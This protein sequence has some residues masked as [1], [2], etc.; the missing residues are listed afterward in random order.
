MTIQAYHLTPDDWL[1]AIR[2]RFG[3]RPNV[4]PV[5]QILRR[6]YVRSFK[7]SL[8]MVDAL[9][10]ELELPNRR[11]RAALT[12]LRNEEALFQRRIGHLPVACL[13]LRVADVLG[14]QNSRRKKTVFRSDR[15]IAGQPRFASPS[16]PARSSQMTNDERNEIVAAERRRITTISGHPTSKRYPRF[17]DA[18]TD[19]D[20]SAAA[21]SNLLDAAA[22]DLDAALA[23]AGKPQ[24]PAL[25]AGR[26][27]QPG[28]LGLGTPV[29]TER[30]PDSDAG[31]KKAAS[32][33]NARFGDKGVH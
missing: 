7:L 18:L 13:R 15:C 3:S 1:E 14:G 33:A 30:S 20:L 16:C 5:A 19:S 29:S 6:E 22:Q 24:L 10:R 11:V 12:L 27:V 17:T 4:V 9:C 23:A 25:E 21:C 26:S 32:Q 31:W 2:W 28:A 8:A